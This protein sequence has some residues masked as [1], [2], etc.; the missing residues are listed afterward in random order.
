MAY[1]TFRGVANTPRPIAQM[2]TS[3][4]MRETQEA[5]TPQEPALSLELSALTSHIS[6]LQI[7]LDGLQQQ[8]DPVMAPDGGKPDG[9]TTAPNVS[10]GVVVDALSAFSTRIATMRHQVLDLRQRLTV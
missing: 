3:G 10:R 9:V 8:L 1:E 4:N 5:A 6:E 2:V 7:E